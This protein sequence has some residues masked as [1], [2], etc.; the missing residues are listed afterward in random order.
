MAK[1][2][3]KFYS[4]CEKFYGGFFSISILVRVK[5]DFKNLNKVKVEK[6]ISIDFV[7]IL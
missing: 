1:F 2:Y 5:I 3:F 4:I 6:Q 7:N